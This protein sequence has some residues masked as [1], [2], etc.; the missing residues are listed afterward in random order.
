MVPNLRKIRTLLQRE[1]GMWVLKISPLTEPEKIMYIT[2]E[3][4]MNANLITAW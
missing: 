3:E 4:N 1:I 2:A